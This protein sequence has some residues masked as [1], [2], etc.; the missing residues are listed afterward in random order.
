MKRKFARLKGVNPKA[1]KYAQ[2]NN[3]RPFVFGFVTSQGSAV[4]RDGSVPIG[5]DDEMLEIW[6]KL[7]HLCDLDAMPKK[8]RKKK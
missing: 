3:R 4:L 1:D 5:A 2:K 6:S 7:C 8:T